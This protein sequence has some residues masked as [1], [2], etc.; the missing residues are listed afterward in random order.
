MLEYLKILNGNL[1]PEFNKD[2]FEYQVNADEDAISL[3]ME[4]KSEDDRP[5]TIYGNDNLT[6]GENH[7]LLEIFDG[8]KVNTYTLTVY[9][10]ESKEVFLN[11]NIKEK[12]E[13]PIENEFIYELITPI[14]SVICFLIIIFLYV[15]LFRKK[16]ER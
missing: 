15:L 3:V 14:I 6:D 2:T 9:K 16:K 5:V 1:S 12:V 7:V 8:T 10:K 4:Y 11:D 13:V